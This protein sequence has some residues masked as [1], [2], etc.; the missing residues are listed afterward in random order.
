MK[1]LLTTNNFGHLY[2]LVIGGVLA[3]M[4]YQV[5]YAQK[6]GDRV[7]V[8]INDLTYTQ[9]QV[10]SYI[11]LKECLRKTDNL[12][13]PLLVDKNNWPD[14]LLVFVD[15]MI[16][17]QEVTR[18]GSYLDVSQL[19]D[20]YEKIVKDK[21]TKHVSLASLAQRL[22]FSDLTIAQTLEDILRIAYFRRSKMKQASMMLPLQNEDGA[23]PLNSLP[24]RQN[25]GN[26]DVSEERAAKWFKTLVEQ[27]RVRYF[28]GS[29]IYVEIF[30][31]QGN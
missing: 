7:V 18:L 12:Q 20:Q 8:A 17:L 27:S 16:L 4:W 30:P 28:E 5:G 24:I 22:G 3:L 9:R 1:K 31:N 26:L 11:T 14:A 21:L 6:L 19:I 25:S 15:D 23:D 29:K 10:E 2:P 13:S